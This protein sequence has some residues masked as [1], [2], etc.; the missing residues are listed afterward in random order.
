MK[1]G[2]VSVARFFLGRSGVVWSLVPLLTLP[3]AWLWP[4]HHLPWPS[5]WQDGA[6]LA[7]VFAAACLCRHA[8]KVQWSWLAAVL[9]AA[10][11]VTMQ[12][13]TG[14]M[15]FGGDALMVLL[16]VGAFALALIVGAALVTEGPGSPRDR[17]LDAI[18][19]STLVAALVSVGIAGA[20]WTGAESLGLW[21]T[22]LPPGARPFANVSQPNH[23]CSLLFLALCS[24]LLLKESGRI[25]R[26]GFWLAASFLLLGMVI[27]GSRTGWLQVSLL[28][29][30]G[31]SAAAR[32]RSSVRP[33]DL[34]ILTAIYVAVTLAWPALNEILLLTGGRSVSEQID[35]GARMPLWLALLDARVRHGFRNLG[36]LATSRPI[37]SRP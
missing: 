31:I 1:T 15:F 21:A 18:A 27:S 5:A 7:A 13:L 11:S 23:L 30:L 33:L 32:M 10:L 37:E 22:D 9:I 25:G 2:N 36:R 34:L 4:N 28:L 8:G 19:L 3:L 29:V 12:W 26:V 20:Q 6:A 16:Y 14:K 35:G 24:A 17:G